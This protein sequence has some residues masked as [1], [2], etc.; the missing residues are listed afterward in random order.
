MRD[1]KIGVIVESFRTD[2]E[3]AIKKAAALGVSG[4][5]VFATFGD[6]A[7]ENV[8][9]EKIKNFKRMCCENNLE[10]SAVCGDLGKGFSNPELNPELIGKSKE[11]MNIAKELGVNIV[12][13][14][15][16]VVPED[17]TSDTYK[18]MQEACYE[19]ATYADSIGSKFAVETGPEKAV[20]LASF[21]DS[22]NSTGVSV[23]LDPANLVMCVGD[24]PAKAVHTLKKYII[25]THAKDGKMLKPTDT[26]VLYDGIE[27]EIQAG[28]SFIELPLGQGNVNWDEYLKA[29]DDIGY[30]GF[31]TIEREVGENPEADIARAV[32]FLREKI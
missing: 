7:P 12:T 21:L 20:V 30:K 14:H 17:N 26:K 8:T 24:D 22:L 15:I 3:T 13:T 6:L 19:L 23:N 4:I 9:P 31:L 32:N 1:F 16:G 29:L 11:I 25:H 2:H 27:K 28:T 18:I 10:I 5:Q